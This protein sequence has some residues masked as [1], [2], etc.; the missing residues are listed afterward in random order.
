[1]QSSRDHKRIHVQIAHQQNK[2]IFGIGSCLSEN[3]LNSLQKG[4]K[5]VKSG[6][7]GKLSLLHH[8][9][10]K[11]RCL[12]MGGEKMKNFVIDGDFAVNVS[13]GRGSI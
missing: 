10:M 11:I 4:L 5:L 8:S 1:M 7:D 3:G 12:E 6:L 13:F 2:L 9:R